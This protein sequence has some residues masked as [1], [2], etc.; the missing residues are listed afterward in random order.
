MRRGR[1]VRGARRTGPG[2]GRARPGGACSRR[3]AS[4]GAR[5]GGACA[6][7]A[8]PG[9]ERRPD[10]HR[11]PAALSGPI[12]FYDGPVE[13]A[14]AI[15]IEEINA[16]GGVLGRPLEWVSADMASD[17]AKA[18]SAAQEV[19][20]KGADA[21]IVSCDFDMG[22]GAAR[23][24]TENNLVSIQ[25]AGGELAGFEGLG[26]LHYNAYPGTPSE[27]AALAQFAVDNGWKS[28]YL[29]EDP[30]IAY[31]TDLCN[32][33]AEAFEAFG[34]T[35]AGRD[36]FQNDDP[37]IANQISTMQGANPDVVIVCSYLPGAGAAIK[38][39]RDVAEIP[40]LTG[41]AQDGTFWLEGIPGAS[42]IYVATLASIAGDD[43][44]PE[45]NEFV[46]K[47]KESTGEDLP[48]AIAMQGYQM[49]KILAEG[50]ERAGTTEGDKVGAELDKLTDFPVLGESFTYTP[51]CH[52]TARPLTIIQI[53]DGTL[54][55]AALPQ[56][57]SI[58]AGK[59]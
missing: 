13:K 40:I 37:S 10:R 24:G 15:A 25:C 32:F 12:N 35:I 57:A 28:L 38:Q 42:D 30:T 7:R 4:R 8:G 3:A 23:V 46:A 48:V 31:D 26:A 19:I 21:L 17:P 41:I 2:A 14:A 52:K 39:I 43:A 9:A 6:G 50:M 58:P 16:A 18:G 51:T 56:P 49:V 45:I 1:R 20:D 54:S 11:L 59:C 47:Y 55:F 53:Q 34:G 33:T 44:R 22:Q 5:A 36:T 27:G 29:L